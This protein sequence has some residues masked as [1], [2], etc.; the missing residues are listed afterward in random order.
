M[1]AKWLLMSA[2]SLLALATLF[3]TPREAK[4]QF[5]YYSPWYSYY[6]YYPG[7]YYYSGWP[8]YYGG[9]YSPYGP[10]ADT[11]YASPQGSSYRSFYAEPQDT[12][13]TASVTVQV[14]A[15]AEVWFGSMLTRQQG[16]ERN[17]V[18]PPLPSGA[19]VYDIRARWLENGQVVDRTK[20]VK[21]RGGERVRVNFLEERVPLPEPADKVKAPAE[22][23]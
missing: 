21:V 16:S 14:P 9:Y 2:T 17:F 23:P 20:Q 19:Y 15:N 22:N 12:S 18:S 4:A 1:Y 3:A 8:T 11:I 10:R 6:G 7:N 13:T 5:G